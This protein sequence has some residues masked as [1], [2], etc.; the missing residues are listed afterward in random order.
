MG[1]SRGFSDTTIEVLSL[2]VN[3]PRNPWYGLE[4]CRE[5]G[6]KSGTIY[7][8]LARLESLGVL[9]SE[10][11]QADPTELGRPRRRLY[12][13]TPGGAVTARE[14]VEERVRAL[15]RKPLRRHSAP[16]QGWVMT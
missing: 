9:E 4:L 8:I 3:D 6:L 7:P 2:L 1:S 16:R 5:A 15:Q 11:E 12:R 10:F 14:A 13:L